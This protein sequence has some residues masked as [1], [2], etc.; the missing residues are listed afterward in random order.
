MGRRSRAV[1]I[2]VV[3][4]TSVL[5]SGC[6]TG[7]T[8]TATP[9]A[10]P[11]PAPSFPPALIGLWA[12]DVSYPNGN[13]GAMTLVVHPCAAEGTTPQDVGCGHLDLAHLTPGGNIFGC[14]AILAYDRMKGDAFVFRENVVHN[15][16][17][18][19]GC[20][21]CSAQLTPLQDG[22]LGLAEDCPQGPEGAT[23][24]TL[25]RVGPAPAPSSG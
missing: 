17:P 23:H 6:A 13:S 7:S 1:Q 18:H 11:T 9:V 16:G 19:S 20:L 2:L 25:S 10:S 5:L 4:A 8:P 15:W 22:T 21:S 12:G 3:V 24:G 14:V